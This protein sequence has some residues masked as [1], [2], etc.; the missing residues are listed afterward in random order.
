MLD[1]VSEPEALK[2]CEKCRAVKSVTEFFKAKLAA[3]GCQR[4]CKAC[5]R[6]SVVAYWKTPRFK[7]LKRSSSARH[8]LRLKFDVAAH[9]SSGPPVCACRG[10]G[11]SDI[12]F[13]SIDHI[14]GGGTKHRKE[15]KIVG[16]GM[17]RWLKLNGFPAGYRILCHN[18]NQARGHYGYCPHEK[19]GK[20]A[21]PVSAMEATDLRLLEAARCLTAAGT[22][23]TLANLA[24]ACD[25]SRMTISAKRERLASGG[26][27][28]YALVAGGGQTKPAKP[29]SVPGC[30]RPFC[31]K[32]LC[33][34]HWQ[35]QRCY[36]DPR[37]EIPFRVASA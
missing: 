22:K 17:Y 14:A 10:C 12:E 21:K 7:Q 5:Q 8:R 16:T 35:R 27:W 25:A 11:V 37:A 20:T 29:C 2:L 28:P 33:S 1:S 3:D 34:G 6:D 13:L 26:R 32:G 15:T 9:Y 18:C 30:P 4:W 19:M 31:A 36:G 24:S 23:L